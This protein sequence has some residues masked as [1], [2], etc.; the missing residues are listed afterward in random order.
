MLL[1]GNYLSKE[2]FSHPGEGRYFSPSLPKA[3]TLFHFLFKNI[4]LNEKCS[5][6]T[7]TQKA[8]SNTQEVTSHPSRGPLNAASLAPLGICGTRRTSANNAAIP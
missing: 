5:G 4:V 8:I 2:M 7:F 6:P 3:K 1:L